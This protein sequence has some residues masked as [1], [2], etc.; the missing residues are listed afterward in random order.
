MH[1]SLQRRRLDCR[2]KVRPVSLAICTAC[3]SYRVPAYK[4]SSSNSSSSFSSHP[5]LER[6][7][8]TRQWRTYYRR[9]SRP[10]A[11]LLPCTLKHAVNAVNAVCGCWIEILYTYKHYPLSKRVVAPRHTNIQFRR[12]QISRDHLLSTLDGTSSARDRAF[13]MHS[14]AKHLLYDLYYLY[15]YILSHAVHALSHVLDPS[16]TMV[17]RSYSCIRKRLFPTP[18]ILTKSRLVV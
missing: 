11:V 8:A 1:V 18:S 2:S 14:S 4:C 16:Q 3:R 7:S 12:L 10:Q 5:G 15:T 9:C 17:R 13:T 6:P